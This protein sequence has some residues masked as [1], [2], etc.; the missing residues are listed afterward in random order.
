MTRMGGE[1]A[2]VPHSSVEAPWLDAEQQVVWRD[3]LQATAR[4]KNHLDNDLRR[5]GLDLSQ[6]E[7]LVSLS[8]APGRAMRMSA[9]AE[10]VHQSRSRLTHA[11]SRMERRGLVVRTHAPRDRRGVVAQLTD[12]GFSLLREAAP[13]HVRAV[14][15]VLVDVVGDQDYRALGRA[16]AAVLAASEYDPRTHTTDRC[17]DD[18]EA[19]EEPT[20]EARP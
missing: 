3:W 11:V 8:E 2:R 16:M 13:D 14:R 19:S 1:T 12:E 18:L 4:I 7:I 9:L 5:R 6:Y 10:A 15:R 17:R 20:C